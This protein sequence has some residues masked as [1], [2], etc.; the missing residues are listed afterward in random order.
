MKNR[1]LKALVLPAVIF[2][3]WYTASSFGLVNSYILPHPARIFKTA[4]YLIKDGILFKHLLVSLYRVAVGFSL[5]F[6][7]AFLLAL[8]ISLN[9]SLSDYISASLEFLRH[10][11]PIA[12]IPLLILWLGIG[13]EPKITVIILATFFPVFLNTLNGITNS[14]KKLEEV[15]EIFG[16]NKWEKFIRITLPQALPSIIVGMQIG[17]G[18]SWRSLIGA[19]LIAASSGIGYMIIDAE[20]LSRPDIIIVGVFTIGLFGYLIDYLFFK[21]TDKFIHQGAEEDKVHAQNQ[22]FN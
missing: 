9:R 22:G 8:I 10:I 13:E 16:L 7:A 2:I 1:K 21:I 11:P 18:Y 19:E 17:L 4:L 3:M 12:L 20:Q 15:G 14:S 5:T 6:I